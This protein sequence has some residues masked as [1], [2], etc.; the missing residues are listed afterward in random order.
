MSI[1]LGYHGLDSWRGEEQRRVREEIVIG[2]QTAESE[3]RERDGETGKWGK[4]KRKEREMH[5]VRNAQRVRIGRAR[6]SSSVR[7]ETSVHLKMD[8]RGIS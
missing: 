2:K 8:C 6:S 7:I 4:R 3:S 1:Y 5:A